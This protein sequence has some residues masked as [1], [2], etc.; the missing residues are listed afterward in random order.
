[1]IP[2]AERELDAVERLS[3]LAEADRRMLRGVT[4]RRTECPRYSDADRSYDVALWGVVVGEVVRDDVPPADPG[5]PRHLWHAWAFPLPGA[6]ELYS[7]DEAVGN[8]TSTRGEAVDELL[9]ALAWICE[10]LGLAEAEA[11]RAQT[12]VGPG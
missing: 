9:R 5:A 4:L 7:W 11:V 1:M 10:E 6:E 12:L 8:R 2:D 3:R